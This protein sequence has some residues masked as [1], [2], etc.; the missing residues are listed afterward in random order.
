MT[1]ECDGAGNASD[2]QAWLDNTGG[3]TAED[4]CGNVSNNTAASFII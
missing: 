3:E 4:L 1:V 2:L